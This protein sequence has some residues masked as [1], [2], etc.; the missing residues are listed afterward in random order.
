MSSGVSL[1]CAF[2]ARERSLTAASP[3]SSYR[4]SHLYAVCRDTPNVRQAAAT[5]VPSMIDRMSASRSST[6]LLSFHGIPPS[7]RCRL[8]SV[9]DVLGLSVSD[10]LG[11]NCQG[12]TRTGPSRCSRWSDLGVH[13]GPE[14]AFEAVHGSWQP[15]RREPFQ[16]DE[17]PSELSNTLRVDRGCARRREIVLPLVQPS[18]VAL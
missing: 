9:S 2:G 5:F 17:V 3:P 10:V 15:L 18:I 13:D 7:C 16:D 8:N 1:G 6:R 11:P 4:L 14:P 12:C